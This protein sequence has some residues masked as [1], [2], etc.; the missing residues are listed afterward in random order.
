[1]VHCQRFAIIVLWP[2]SSHSSA[3][4]ICSSGD[5]VC[6][7]LKY[8]QEL[9]LFLPN[10]CN[11]SCSA[12]ALHIC[13]VTIDVF[14]ARLSRRCIC[15]L[16][17]SAGAEWC[18]ACGVSPHLSQSVWFKRHSCCVE[19]GKKTSLCWMFRHSSKNISYWNVIIRCYRYTSEWAFPLPPAVAAWRMDKSFWYMKS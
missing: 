10:N 1:M 12:L 19:G 7:R 14:Q 17:S 4:G 8:F 3:T 11:L 15:I 13:A 2:T 5:C 6:S 9:C 16:V 18:L